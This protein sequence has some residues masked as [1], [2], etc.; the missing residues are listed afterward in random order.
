MSTAPALWI[1]ARGQTELRE[2]PFDV[3]ADALEVKTFFSGISRGTERLVLGG[4]VPESEHATMRAPFQEGEFGF[5]VKYGYSA[6]GEVQTGDRAGEIVF[7]LFPHQ[8]RFAVPSDAA[9]TVPPNIP[10]ARAILAANMETALNILWDAAA[11]SGDR[12]AIV[13]CGVVGALTGYLAAR[14]PGTEVTLVDTNPARAALARTLGCAFAAPGDAPED[15]DLVIHTSAS[16]AGL[17]TALQCA[18][19]EATVIEASWYGDRATT[20]PLG[21]RFHQRRLRIIGS[22]VGRIPPARTPRWDYARRL[23]KAIALLDDP[24]LDALVPTESSFETLAEDYPRI[25][26]YPDTLCHRVRYAR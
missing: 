8:A 19:V 12:L 13:G 23:A 18:G 5:P 20:V 14:L 26:A 15:C 17:N 21:G 3:A 25:L 16:D 10:P 6:V 22:Q 4:A 24:C 1:T 7:A 9:H 11:G 2:T